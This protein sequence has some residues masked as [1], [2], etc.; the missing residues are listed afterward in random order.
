[1]TPAGGCRNPLHP[2]SE[3]VWT[4][5]SLMTVQDS[6]SLLPCKQLRSNSNANWSHVKRRLCLCDSCLLKLSAA[7]HPFKIAHFTHIRFDLAIESRMENS[8]DDYRIQSFDMDTQMLLKTALKGYHPRPFKNS[9]PGCCCCYFGHFKIHF[10]CFL[11]RSKF[12]ESRKGIKHH[13]RSIVEG[14]GVQQGGWTHLLHHRAGSSLSGL[15]Y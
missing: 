12:S 5:A 11:I 9:M 15:P 8:S 13:H 3:R 7:V 10:L 4:A 2:P 6:G 14:P 1:M